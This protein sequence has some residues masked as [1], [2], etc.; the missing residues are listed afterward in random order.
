M[1]EAGLEPARPCRRQDLNLMRLPISPPGRVS[2]RRW[3]SVSCRYGIQV[4]RSRTLPFPCSVCALLDEDCLSA[5]PQRQAGRSSQVSHPLRVCS[6]KTK[7]NR[8]S[9]ASYEARG[10][11]WWVLTGSNRR[12]TP[13]KGAALPAELRTQFP[14]LHTPE[15]GLQKPFMSVDG[16]R[17][18]TRTGTPCGGGF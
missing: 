10:I 12:P 4:K 2:P 1:P 15:R 16:A 11:R 18:R 3:R 5:L 13:C 14:L 7:L 17:G 9:H 6:Y 8:G